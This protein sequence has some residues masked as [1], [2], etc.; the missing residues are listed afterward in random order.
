[1]KKGFAILLLFLMVGPIYAQEITIWAEKFEPYGYEENGKIAGFASDIVRFIVEDSQIKVKKWTMAPWARALLETQNTPNS[2][3]YTVVRRPER[4]N[5][6]HWIGPI[7]NRNQYLY[8]LRSRDD[9][10]VNSME[11][12][13]KYKLG[14]VYGTAVTELLLSKGLKPY[15][16]P[17]HDQTLKMLLVGRL[18]LIVH[19]DY[20]LAY[21]AK[22]LGEDFSKFEPVLLVDG[23]RKYY[24]VLN[25]DSSPS[26]V[27]K[28]QNSFDK[29]VFS[30]GLRKMQEKYLK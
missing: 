9:I 23:S 24:I 26:I 8:K 29:L 10:V 18:D 12:A 7:S 4:E 30:G 13:K 16:V 6:F 20:S 1:M 19:L 15:E 22:K 28:F 21:M 3:L 2:V 11:D 14:A 17:N 25:K 5:M 27:E